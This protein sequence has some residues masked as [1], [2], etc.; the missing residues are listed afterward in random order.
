MAEV[1]LTPAAALA[2]GSSPPGGGARRPRPSGALVR[3]ARQG[4]LYTLST[5]AAKAAG[6]VLLG[7]YLDPALLPQADYGRLQLLE[8]TWQVL[9]LVMGLGLASGVLKFFHDD[10]WQADRDALAA[11]ALAAVAVSAALTFGGVWAASP[12]LA[13]WLVDD[14]AAV[15]PVRLMGAYVALKL[16]GAVPLVLLR[17]RERAGLFALAVGLE[18]ALLVGATWYF[19]GVRRWG[20]EGA[21]AGYAAAAAASTML[22]LA[23]SARRVLRPIR[24]RLVGPLVRFGAPLALGGLT[25]VALNAGD[26]FLLKALAPGGP[27]AA[28]EAVAVYGL[29]AKYG[30]LINLVF[31]QSFQLAFSVAGLRAL[32][33]S[34]EGADVH[35]RTLRHYAAVTGWAVLGVSVL[36]R[37]VTAW[38]SP[39]PSYLA[40]EPLVLPIAL[41]FFAYGVYFVGMNVLYAGGRTGAIAGGVA[42]AA[43]AN[44]V[45]NLAAI[46]ALGAMGAALVSLV[47]YAGLAAATMHRAQRATPVPYAWGALASVLLLIVGLWAAAQASADSPAALRLACRLGLVAAYPPLLVAAGVYSWAEVRALAGAAWRR[48]RG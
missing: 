8:A 48:V 22:L 17:A 34:G 35:R 9:I 7:L 12:V 29:A 2:G 31:V 25:S 5:L 20:L 46:P 19:V 47:S 28:A 4:A 30:G 16:V 13:R 26:R 18:A 36:A 45:L 23:A 38:V 3:L 10:A 6:F 15:G 11:T 39:D 21:A 40:A 24:L 43:A 44:V 32:S 33:A 14:P 27:T 42:G 1:P 41:G 37:D